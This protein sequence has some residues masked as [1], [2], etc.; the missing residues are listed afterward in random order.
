MTVM[1]LNGDS[2]GRLSVT[3]LKLAASIAGGPAFL[4]CGG[5]SPPA[6]TQSMKTHVA[7]LRIKIERVYRP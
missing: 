7:H 3:T 5:A 1:H 6:A 2:G 4:R